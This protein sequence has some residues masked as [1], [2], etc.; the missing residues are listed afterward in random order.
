MS[1]G[2]EAYRIF[3]PQWKQVILLWLGREDVKDKDK[4]KEGLFVRW[5]SLRVESEIFMDIKPI[6]WQ[7]QELMNLRLVPW[8][9]RLFGR[10]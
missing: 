7:Q 4:E 1:G 8:L 5:L 6:F 2:G 10:W 9:L 3:E